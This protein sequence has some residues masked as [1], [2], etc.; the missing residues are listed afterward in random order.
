MNQVDVS[1]IPSSASPYT[2]AVEEMRWLDE[3]E[4]RAWRGYLHMHRLLQVQLER[5]LDAEAG[6]SLADYAVLV[7]LSEADGH[8]LRMTELAGR[9]QWSKSRLSHQVGRMEGRG[10]LRRA[11]CPTDARGSLA[12]LTARGLRTIAKAAPTHVAGV[13][14]HLLDHLSAE[15]V[16]VLGEIADVVTG[17]LDGVVEPAYI[18]GEGGERC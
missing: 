3:G 1:T 10:L 13:R 15:Q 4:A 11:E 6:L 18:D 8:R 2:G 5:E 12:V 17:H 9:M 14:R 7:N 16:K